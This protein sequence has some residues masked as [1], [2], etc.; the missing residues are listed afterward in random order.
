MTPH[1]L[2]MAHMGLSDLIKSYCFNL[3]DQV[4]TYSANIY[5]HTHTLKD[6]FT[7]GMLIFIN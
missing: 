7:F 5:I 2:I 4:K 3:T 6:I 1:C